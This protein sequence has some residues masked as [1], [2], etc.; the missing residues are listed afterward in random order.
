MTDREITETVSTPYMGFNDGATKSRPDPSDPTKKRSYRH[1]FESPLIRLMKDYKYRDIYLAGSETSERIPAKSIIIY[2]YYEAIEKDFGSGN[3][4]SMIETARGLKDLIH[5]I[6]DQVCGSD[7]NLWE[8][9][10]VYLVAHSMGGLICRCFLQNKSISTE[11]DRKLVRKVFTYGTP[12]N[13]IESSSFASS[14]GWQ[15]GLNVPLGNFNRKTMAKYLDLP[16]NAERVDTLDGKFTPERFFCLVGTNY[17]DYDVA[18]GW[19]RRFAGEMSDGLVLIK[20]ATVQGAPRAFV[21]RSHSGPYGIVNSEEGYQN[22]I[23]FLF[24][25]VRVDGVLKVDEL[26]LPPSVK[27]KAERDNQIVYVSYYI[28]STVATRG[29]FSLKLSE[30]HRD[31]CSAILRTRDETL[32][33]DA[34][35]P[36]LFSVFLDTENKTKQD[37]PLVF[38]VDIVVSAT[39]YV[40]GN[41]FWNKHSD[42][43]YLYRNTITVTVGKEEA[44]WSLRYTT[45]DMDWSEKKG[46]LSE[47]VN[48]NENLFH[49]DL[50]SGKGFR[51]KL[52]LKVFSPDAGGPSPTDSSDIPPSGPVTSTKDNS[53]YYRIGNTLVSI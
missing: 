37:F 10:Q 16:N 24:G 38:S 1:I 8:Q 12:H 46:S 5:K 9:F 45:D 25:N 52:E 17:K 43:E 14:L 40:I 33:P 26:P 15:S 50:Q 30:R 51:G 3:T 47:C 27:K 34:N 13:G 7:E 19:S 32:D 28:E 21:N 35:P 18:W 22:L 31:M 39:D 44:G 29:T 4:F 42:V 53:I 23:R 48:S 20:N 6:R 2:R 11:S 36:K 41:G 49:I